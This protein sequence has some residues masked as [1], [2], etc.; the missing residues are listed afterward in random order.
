ME[1]VVNSQPWS[2]YLRESPGTYCIGGWVGPRACL[3]G[4]GKSRFPRG[5]DP[6]TVQS[7]ANRYTD[8]YSVF[9]EDPFNI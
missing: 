2:L 8:C 3:D 7:V 9:S 5:F 1:W 6:R 4:C